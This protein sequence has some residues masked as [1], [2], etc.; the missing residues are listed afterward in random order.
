[1]NT[2]TNTGTLTPQALAA[3]LGLFGLL[4][5]GAATDGALKMQA[6]DHAIALWAE[7]KREKFA[8]F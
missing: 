5:Q 2:G 6:R 7:R 4:W 8:R 3:A 1:M